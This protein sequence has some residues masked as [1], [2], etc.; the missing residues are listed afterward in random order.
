MF[1]IHNIQLRK[2]SN[3]RDYTCG[4]NS[5][6]PVCC[7]VWYLTVWYMFNLSLKRLYNRW[8]GDI[9]NYEICYIRCPLCKVMGRVVTITHCS[10]IE[11]KPC[12]KCDVHR[13]L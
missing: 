4:K 7:I 10:L 2:V 12:K 9:Y 3:I 8:V 6:I 11:D 13:H 5:G 1:V